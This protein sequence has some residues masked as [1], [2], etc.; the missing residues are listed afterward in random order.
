MSKSTA[1]RLVLSRIDVLPNE[2]CGNHHRYVTRQS[3]KRSYPYSPDDVE[4]QIITHCLQYSQR[5]PQ[6]DI[7]KRAPQVHYGRTQSVYLRSTA[8]K[9]N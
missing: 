8:A 6:Y 5:K 7:W 3:Y 4:D 1:K 9:P 2:K